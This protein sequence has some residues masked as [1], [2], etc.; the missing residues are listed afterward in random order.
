MSIITIS[1][2]S[3][4]C[5]KEVAEKVSHALGY[6]C[7]SRDIILE[8]SEQFNIPEIKLIRAIHDSPSILDRFTSGKERYISFFRASPTSPRTQM[9]QGGGYPLLKLSVHNSRSS[10]LMVHSFLEPF[11]M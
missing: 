10:A 1:R 6:E 8:T 4:S 11:S 9:H 7:I 2:G 3:Y 5:G